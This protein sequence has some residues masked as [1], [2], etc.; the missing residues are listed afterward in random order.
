M[1]YSGILGVALLQYLFI[2]SLQGNF[3]E[4]VTVEW[5]IM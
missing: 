4:M 5:S 2:I 3:V 1:S